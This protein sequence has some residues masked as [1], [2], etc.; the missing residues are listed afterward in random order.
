MRLTD[1]FTLDD[2][3]EDWRELAEVTGLD[4]YKELVRVFGG[5]PVYIPKLENITR[6]NRDD[7]IVKEFYDGMTVK[8]LAAKYDRVQT[9]IYTILRKARKRAEKAAE[10][11]TKGKS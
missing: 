7:I 3:N 2:L 1:D 10:T 5:I 6:K 4:T 9:T 11:N 8:A